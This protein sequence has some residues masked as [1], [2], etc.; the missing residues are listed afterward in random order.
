MPWEFDRTTNVLSYVV[1]TTVRFQYPAP[2]TSAE[3]LKL[4]GQVLGKPEI[5]RDE[6][7]LLYVML[8][9]IVKD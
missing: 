3:A 2:R 4:M 5:T 1:G 9:P 8:A 6:V 7:A